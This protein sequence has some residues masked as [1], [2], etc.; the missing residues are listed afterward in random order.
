[1]LFPLDGMVNRISSVSTV[2]ESRGILVSW[3]TGL[4]STT[5]TKRSIRTLVLRRLRLVED[6]GNNTGR[7]TVMGVNVTIE[8]WFS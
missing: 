1:M 6:F 5:S 4:T 2:Q 3:A 8:Q 7:I